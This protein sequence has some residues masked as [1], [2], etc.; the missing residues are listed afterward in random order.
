MGVLFAAVSVVLAAHSCRDAIMNIFSVFVVVDMDNQVGKLLSYVVALKFEHPVKPQ[1]ARLQDATGVRYKNSTLR[2][3]FFLA[4]AA[5]AC[6]TVAFALGLNC[7]PL[8][9]V[10]GHGFVSNAY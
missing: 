8:T 9:V 4:P 10:S 3:V 7:I 1:F 6:L 5:L 2:A